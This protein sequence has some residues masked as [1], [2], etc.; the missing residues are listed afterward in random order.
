MKNKIKLLTIFIII[1]MSFAQAFVSLE[2]N[3]TDQKKLTDTGTGGAQYKTEEGTINPNYYDPHNPN[4]GGGISEEDKK[5]ITDKA[6]IVLG[7]IRN[8]GVI[9]AVIA[10]MIIGVKYIIG[11]V[12]EKANY[13]KIL[14]PYVIGVLMIASGG[15][16]VSIVYNAVH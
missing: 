8:I 4:N 7:V 1:L 11:S 12:E 9:V 3:A 16:I 13:K 14:L 5:I 6:G 15:F 10:I 2:V